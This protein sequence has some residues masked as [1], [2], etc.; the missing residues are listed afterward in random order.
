[1]NASTSASCLRSRGPS[2]GCGCAARG[3]PAPSRLRREHGPFQVCLDQRRVDVV[4]AAD[5]AGV[6]Q[7]LRRDVDGGDDVLV[8]FAFGLGRPG[9]PKASATSMVPAHVRKSL[10]VMSRAGDVL[11]VCVDVFGLDRLPLP[12]SS[13]Y[14]NNSSPRSAWHR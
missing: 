1:M 3:T 13:R 6:A 14:L 8:G 10:A 9:R 4:L 11:E 12:S 2:E 7:S 5:A